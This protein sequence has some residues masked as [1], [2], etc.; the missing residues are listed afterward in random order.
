V[1]APLRDAAANLYYLSRGTDF[2]KLPNVV[3]GELS[4]DRAIELIAAAL[5]LSKKGKKNAFAALLEDRDAARD[6]NRY[7]SRESTEAMQSELDDIQARRNIGADRA[8]RIVARGEKLLSGRS[9][10]AL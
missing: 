6:A 7:L 2:R 10:P 3:P 8:K 1:L 4:P 5:S 9:K